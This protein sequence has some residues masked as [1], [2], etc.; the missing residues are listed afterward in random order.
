MNNLQEMIDSIQEDEHRTEKSNQGDNSN[1][2]KICKKCH[3]AGH[4]ANKC[5]MAHEKK[6]SKMKCYICG[7]TGHARSQCP[8]VDDGGAAQSIHKNNS[9]AKNNT[10]EKKKKG[11]DK[12]RAQKMMRGKKK[13]RGQSIDEKEVDILTYPETSVQFIDILSGTSLYEEYS[14]DRTEEEDSSSSSTPL[15]L[16]AGFISPCV[17]SSDQLYDLTFTPAVPEESNHLM[18]Y[19]VGLPPQCST[20]WLRHIQLN[21]G[22]DILLTEMMNRMGSKLRAIGPIGLDYTEDVVLH[23]SVAD[24]QEAFHRQIE[25]ATSSSA[26]S[27]GHSCPQF[28]LIKAIAAP[29][30]SATETVFN[31]A[32]D[33]EDLLRVDI[34][35]DLF[36]TLHDSHLQENPLCIVINLADCGLKFP[37]I[38][39]LLST[40]PNL[41]FSL[42]GRLTHSKRKLLK[43]YA[44]DI[45]LSRLVFAS[46]SPHYPVASSCVGGV[47]L[48]LSTSNHVLFIADVLATIK[49]ITLDE[50]LEQCLKNSKRILQLE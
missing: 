40:F 11:K 31:I 2:E 47:R 20:Q 44:F 41:Y 29:V 19:A 13:E 23:N 12:V 27:S 14:Q 39:V 43:E 33:D 32:D 18:G 7:Q 26:A 3:Q 50:V 21:N 37:T 46:I 28:I 48:E 9:T 49:N 34:D 6:K 16:L 42:D 24:Q 30:S 1:K 4:F 35:R 8:G 17:P 22:E 38:D 36:K 10:G 5:P 25:I 15:P 45:P